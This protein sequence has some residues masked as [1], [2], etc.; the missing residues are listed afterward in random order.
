MALRDRVKKLKL[1]IADAD[2]V[3]T[4]GTLYYTE[5]GETL[6]AFSVLDGLGVKKLKDMGIKVAVISGRTSPPLFKRLEEL[7]VETYGG[8]K[9]KLKLY[10]ELKERYR[11][12][13]E[14]VAFVGDDLVDLPVMKRV[15]F[16]VAVANA[17]EEVKKVALYTTMR[18]GGKGAVREVAD[19]IYTLLND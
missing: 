5:E 18:E 19:L 12:K 7:G 10:E 9:D 11:L 14:E 16:P 15:G 6:K 1:L 3:L 13:D 2:G 4:E 17:E 8:I